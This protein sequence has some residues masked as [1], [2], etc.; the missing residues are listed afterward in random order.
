M[1]YVGIAD[2]TLHYSI[3]PTWLEVLLHGA[4]PQ[5]KSTARTV[6]S[7]TV[8]CTAFVGG[9]CCTPPE[10]QTAKQCYVTEIDCYEL[11]SRH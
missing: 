3:R 9:A 10:P 8:M 4:E 1:C 7:T 6:M 11:V 5:K 2:C